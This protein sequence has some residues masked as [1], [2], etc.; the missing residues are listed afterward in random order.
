[1]TTFFLVFFGVMAVGIILTR[2]ATGPQHIMLLWPLPAMLAVCLLVTA[3]RLP[4]RVRHIATAVLS[5]A[6]ALLLVT[7]VRTTATY[8][9]TYRSDRSWSAIWSPEIYAAVHAVSRSAPEVESVITADWGLGNQVFALA[10]KLC[11]TV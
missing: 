2:Q 10:T 6:L 1:M 8:V 7:Q 11:E 5:V 4:M 3:A 9:H